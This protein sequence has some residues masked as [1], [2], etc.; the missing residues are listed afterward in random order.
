MEQN[1]N[2][3]NLEKILAKVLSKQEELKAEQDINMEEIKF[4]AENKTIKENKDEYE[5]ILRDNNISEILKKD[6]SEM[7]N[8]EKKIVAKLEILIPVIMDDKNPEISNRNNNNDMARDYRA[9]LA[10]A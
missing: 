6:V 4:E 5:E 2:N 10:A 1:R 9:M 8:S 7:T 3:K